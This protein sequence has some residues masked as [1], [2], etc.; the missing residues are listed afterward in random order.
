VE[1]IELPQKV[2]VLAGVAGM[3]LV[4]IGLVKPSDADAYG[5]IAKLF[6]DQCI[7]LFRKRYECA[8]KWE[9]PASEGPLSV[10][11]FISFGIGS[12]E[13]NQPKIID[14]EINDFCIRQRKSGAQYLAIYFW[15]NGQDE[16]KIIIASIRGIQ[17]KKIARAKTGTSH[18]DM[19]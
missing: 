5:L 17:A 4:Q 13:K 14:M 16:R 7:G 6:A 11:S 8:E 3:D 2:K 1:K 19:L 9:M 10:I 15:S 12:R 18:K